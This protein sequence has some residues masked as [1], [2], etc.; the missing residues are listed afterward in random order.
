VSEPD[1]KAF[2]GYQHVPAELAGIRHPALRASGGAAV[3]Q[4]DRYGDEQR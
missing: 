2:V 3:D 1:G 4:P